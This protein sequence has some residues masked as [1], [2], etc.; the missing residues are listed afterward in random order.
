MGKILAEYSR[1]GNL[2]PAQREAKPAVFA[3]FINDY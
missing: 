2:Y 1:F 3:L